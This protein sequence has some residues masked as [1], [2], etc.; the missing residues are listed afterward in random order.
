MI[1][2]DMM[3]EE[4][5]KYSFGFPNDWPVEGHT[6]TLDEMLPA[7]SYTWKYGENKSYFV[8]AEMNVMYYSC[9]AKLKALRAYAVDDQGRLWDM[10]YDADELVS[11]LAPTSIYLRVIT[12]N[13]ATFTWFG[14]SEDATEWEVRYRPYNTSSWTTKSVSVVP[15]PRMKPT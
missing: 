5:R 9:N 8:Q 2:Y 14:G 6:Y 3:D 7:Y 10:K 15:V 11:C 13:S 4:G 12:E 1:T